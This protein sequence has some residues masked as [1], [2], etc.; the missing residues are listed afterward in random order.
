MRQIAIVYGCDDDACFPRPCVCHAFAAG[1][2]D[3]DVSQTSGSLTV[4]LESSGA[5]LRARLNPFWC[6]L[7]HPF[8]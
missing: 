7:C 3:I 1:S 2:V 6:R 8:S 5:W 4:S